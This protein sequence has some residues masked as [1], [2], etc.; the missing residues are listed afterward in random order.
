MTHKNNDMTVKVTFTKGADMLGYTNDSITAARRVPNRLAAL[1]LLGLAS[2]LH[3][4]SSPLTIQPSTSRVGVN[5]TNPSTAL[6]VTCT[7]KATTFQGDGSLLTNL[8]GGIGSG[9]GAYGSRGQFSRNNA[10]TPNTQYDLKADAV[11]L[12]KP[13]DQSS[14]TRFNPGAITNNVALSGP[15][16]TQS[17]TSL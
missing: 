15:V 8:P 5:T 3:A 11:V 6:D 4:Q 13:S 16:V 7:V 14:V 1:V 2:T 12:A 10:T 17:G 9:N